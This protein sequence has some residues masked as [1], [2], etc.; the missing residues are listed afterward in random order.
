MRSSL[1]GRR[2]ERRPVDLVDDAMAITDRVLRTPE[3]LRAAVVA[4]YVSVGT[5]PGTGRLLEPLSGLGKR[6]LLPVLGSDNV[7]D[8][9]AYSGE[10]ALASAGRG[11]VEPV[12]PRLG[13]DALASAEVVLVP[14]LAVDHRGVRL[15][16]G[17]G[18]YDRSLSRLEPGTWVCAL[19]YDD[20]LLE[21]VPADMHDRTVDAVVTPTRTLRL[22][23]RRPPTRSRRGEPF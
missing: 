18:S 22:P 2:R 7:L 9:S 6:V 15:G 4:C 12:G 23:L 3:I 19:I 5:E 20:E 13:A 14:A 16:R 8:W 11:L 21:S 17:G 1:L 10:H